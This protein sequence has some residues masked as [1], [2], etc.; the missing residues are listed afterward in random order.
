ML[1]HNKGVS[2][3]FQYGHEVHYVEIL[4]VF[5]SKCHSTTKLDDYTDSPKQQHGEQ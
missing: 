1:K 2:L 5:I 3:E 4:K